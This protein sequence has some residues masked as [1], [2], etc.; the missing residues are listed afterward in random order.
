MTVFEEYLLIM[1]FYR[2]ENLLLQLCVTSRKEQTKC[3]LVLNVFQ[4]ITYAGII[5]YFP[6]KTAAGILKLFNT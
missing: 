1:S 6:N 2:G 3:Y 5:S 4:E